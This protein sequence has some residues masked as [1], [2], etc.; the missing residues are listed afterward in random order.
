MLL[1]SERATIHV[2]IQQRNGKKSLTTIQGID[3]KFDPAKVLKVLKC[4]LSCNGSVAVDSKLGTVIQLQGDHR[5]GVK[6]FLVRS[7]LSRS[8]SV[9]LHG[10]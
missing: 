2:R 1:E 8:E 4:Q 7:K 10:Y 6:E 3:A 5:G 9:M